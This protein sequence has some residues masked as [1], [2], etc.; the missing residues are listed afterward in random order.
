MKKQ[1]LENIEKNDGVVNTC[2]IC[3]H[4]KLLGKRDKP[5]T[6]TTQWEYPCTRYPQV[7]WKNMDDYCFE[8]K[9][10]EM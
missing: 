4:L 3:R 9:H 6:M 5:G 7:A 2:L 8:F 10:R 1:R